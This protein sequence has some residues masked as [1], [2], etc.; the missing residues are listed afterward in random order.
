MNVL[1]ARAKKKKKISEI[2]L[3]LE[4]VIFISVQ[5][6]DYRRLLFFMWVMLWLKMM[7]CCLG[8]SLVG[9]KPFRWSSFRWSLLIQ[10]LD[11]FLQRPCSD[12][13]TDFIF[14]R[15]WNN[16]NANV[17]THTEIKWPQVFIPFYSPWSCGFSRASMAALA[18][19]ILFKESVKHTVNILLYFY[20][21]LFYFFFYKTNSFFSF[22]NFALTF[23]RNAS[24]LQARKCFSFISYKLG[25]SSTLS[26]HFLG[27]SF[28]I[29]KP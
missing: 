16:D 2:C 11:P 19:M 15:F 12:E 10:D 3:H 9:V 1:V 18:G 27:Q 13:F 28:E 20:F 6:W 5:L 29:Q 17:T 24:F 7:I 22:W 23:I 21:I 26:H 14:L 4:T 25:K 8:A